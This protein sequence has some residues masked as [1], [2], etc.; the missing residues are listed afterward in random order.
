[1][2]SRA[3]YCNLYILLIVH[4]R[5]LYSKVPE[6][7]SLIIH[8]KYEFV[9]FDLIF[10]LF[11]TVVMLAQFI[12]LNNLLNCLVVFL[13][14]WE[15]ILKEKSTQSKNIMPMQNIHLGSIFE[16]KN[17][18]E[19]KSNHKIDLKSMSF[20]PIWCLTNGT[21]YARLWFGI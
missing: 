7:G 4:F 10:I 12:W 19:I 16:N 21:W 3:N 17:I 14:F 11:S 1:M 9:F 15:M 6:A 2:N 13:R 5:K 20:G 18:N 8:N